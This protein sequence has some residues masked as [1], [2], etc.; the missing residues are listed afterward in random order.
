MVTRI[1]NSHAVVCPF[2]V[3]CVLSSLQPVPDTDRAYP[4]GITHFRQ[5]IRTR[6]L[7]IPLFSLF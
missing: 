5:R 6:M 7:C 4:L 3:H 2:A 1:A